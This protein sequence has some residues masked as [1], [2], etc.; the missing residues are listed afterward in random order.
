MPPRAPS[1]SATPRS[2]AVSSTVKSVAQKTRAYSSNISAKKGSLSTGIEA[3]KTS[4]TPIARRARQSPF[5]PIIMNPRERGA[6]IDIL[7]FPLI[8]GASPSVRLGIIKSGVPVTYISK[9]AG[10]M[11]TSQEELLRRLGLSKTTVNRKAKAGERLN[12]G[13]SESVLGLATLVGQVASIVKESGDPEDVDND[14]DPA[15]WLEDW[16]SHPN[17]ALGNALPSAYLDT[18]EGREV[19][20]RLI[21]QMQSGAYA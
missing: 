17:P 15:A 6:P 5:S 19:L 3:Q 14:F 21:A 8:Y 10:T 12:T 11:G 4:K 7:D 9:L 13:Q 16:L 2:T 1:K 20:S 18:H